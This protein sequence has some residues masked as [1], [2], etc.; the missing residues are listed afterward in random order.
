MIDLIVINFNTEAKLSRLVNTL[1]PQATEDDF[2]QTDWRLFLVDNGSTDGSQDYINSVNKGLVEKRIFNKNIG[3]AAAAN[4]T[5]AISTG[6]IIGILNADI[7]F[8]PDDVRAIQR[9]FDEDPE[10]AILGPKQRDEKGDIV[11]GGILG[12]PEHPKHRGWRQNDPDDILYRDKEE[13]YLISGSAY[14]MRRSVWEDITKCPLYQEVSEG[15]IGAFLPTPHYFEETFCTLHAQAHGYRSF[16]DGRVSIGH[17]WHAS[18]EVGGHADRM[19][20][21]SKAIFVN[22]ADKHGIPH[23]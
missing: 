2:N 15:A 20:Q 3:Y 17:S 11:Y 13:M 1:Y 14:F 18:S 19:F 16:Y 5:A 22:A 21:V 4:E 7:W 10:V 6:D 8:T 12:P 23:D 9:A